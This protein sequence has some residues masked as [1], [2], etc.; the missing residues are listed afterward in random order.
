MSTLA[1][2]QAR[3]P[4]VNS[5]GTPTPAALRWQR[6]LINRVGGSDGLTNK[7][8]AEL[9]SALAADVESLTTLVGTLNAEVLALSSDVT[10]L[11]DQVAVVSVEMI[12]QP[13][14]TQDLSE[15]IFQ[16]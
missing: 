16:D 14:Q 6:Q 3:V 11:T 8:L 5:D 2:F 9:V 1:L 10:A 15:M 12:F 13:A 4:F 7:E